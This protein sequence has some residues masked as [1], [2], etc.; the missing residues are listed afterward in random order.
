MRAHEPDSEEESVI[1]YGHA[2]LCTDIC[3]VAGGYLFYCGTE[4]I[5]TDHDGDDHHDCGCGGDRH[6]RV[7]ENPGR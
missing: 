6:Y 2:V 1:V 5:R 7:P 4:C 3:R